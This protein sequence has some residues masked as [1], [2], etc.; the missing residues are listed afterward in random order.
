VRFL[1]LPTNPPPNIDKC[2]LGDLVY[3]KLAYNYYMQSKNQKMIIA[4]LILL[5]LLFLGYFLMSKKSGKEVSDSVTTGSPSSMENVDNTSAF[6]GS[7]FDLANAGGNMTCK[8]SVT[9][10]SYT[11]TGTSYISG[12]N[13]RVDSEVKMSNQPAMASHMISDGEWFYSWSDTL[14][15]GMKMKLESANEVQ[16][17]QG[18]SM[19]NPSSSQQLDKLKQNMDFK[20][21]KWAPDN[22]VFALPK[23]VEF[24]DLSVQAQPSGMPSACAACSYIQDADQK[25]QCLSS[26]K[27]N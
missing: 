4:V 8:Y 25:A 22:S 27:C 16:G 12:R 18:N 7:I 24:M 10:A 21:S 1:I 14:P 19:D 11:M 26:L 2:F 6:S 3:P 9:D 5:L 23:N 13:M 15:Q 20:C 17:N